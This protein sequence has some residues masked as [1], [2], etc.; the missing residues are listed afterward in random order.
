[1]KIARE[2][3][4]Q[5]T[6]RD[7]QLWGSC[8]CQFWQHK[9]DEDRDSCKAEFWFRKGWDQGRWMCTMPAHRWHPCNLYGWRTA[10][11]AEDG[12]HYQRL[13]TSTK[14]DSTQ[15]SL[16]MTSLQRSF[17]KKRFKLLHYFYVLGVMIM[18]LISTCSSNCVCM[19][20]CSWESLSY[21][22]CTT[23]EWLLWWAA[24]GAVRTNVGWKEELLNLY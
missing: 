24:K 11:M 22:Y 20:M 3:Q 2:T 10:Q 21:I 1:M 9:Y 7:R 12:K 4:G 16:K 23:T 6:T 14:N 18:S 5:R 19:Q 17:T 13:V 8:F 15:G